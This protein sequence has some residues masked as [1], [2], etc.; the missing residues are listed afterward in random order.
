MELYHALPIAIYLLSKSFPSDNRL[1]ITQRS[2][3]IQILR[4]IF[5]FYRGIFEV[6]ACYTVTE[7]EPYACCLAVD[8]LKYKRLIVHGSCLVSLMLCLAHLLLRH[9]YDFLTFFLS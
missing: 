4:R 7:R 8:H 1:S 6:Q 2:D 3:L 9:Q 5:P